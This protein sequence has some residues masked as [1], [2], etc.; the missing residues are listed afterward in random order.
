M[1]EKVSSRFSRQGHELTVVVE[2]KALEKQRKEAEVTLV[3]PPGR[4]FTLHC[5][6]GAYLNG[7]D[8]APPPLAFLSAS[9]GF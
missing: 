6:E 9:V 3:A 7:D 1:D 5:D 2:A 8:T 4:T